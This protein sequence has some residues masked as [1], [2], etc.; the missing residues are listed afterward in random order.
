[1]AMAAIGVQNGSLTVGQFVVV[2]AFMIGSS[3]FDG[4]V[5]F[6]TFIPTLGWG[7]GMAAHA[8]TVWYQDRRQVE[9]LYR[10]FDAD[11]TTRHDDSGLADGELTDSAVEM[12]DGRRGRR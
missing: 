9:K 10:D 6:G 2:N 1:M 11:M 4:G 3:A 8:V 12:L 5:S 7:A